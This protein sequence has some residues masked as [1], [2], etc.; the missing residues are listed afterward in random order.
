MA[1]TTAA[2]YISLTTQQQEEKKSSCMGRMFFIL[3]TYEEKEFTLSQIREVRIIKKQAG[4][5]LCQAHAQ[6]D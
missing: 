4:A 1:E 3:R 5:E 2:F 6:V